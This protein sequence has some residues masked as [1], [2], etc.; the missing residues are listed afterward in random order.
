MPVIDKKMYETLKGW[1]DYDAEKR[2][3]HQQIMYVNSHD[4]T[5][6]NATIKKMMFEMWKEDVH[7][8]LFMSLYSAENFYRNMREYYSHIADLYLNKPGEDDALI[9]IIEDMPPTCGWIVL[10][11]EDLE[12]LSGKAEVMQE[13]MESVFTF[14]SNMPSIILVGNGEYQEVFA[15]C[16]FALNEMADG[17]AATEEDDEVMV[18]CY[19]QETEPTREGITYES[20]DDQRD[21][22]SFYWDLLYRQLEKRCFDYGD[23][24]K[25][26]KETMEYIIPR[27][28]AEQV[29]RKDIRLIENIGAI[30]RESN[31]RLDGCTPWEFDAAQECSEGLHGA[32]VNRYGC[33]DDLSNGKIMFYVAIKHPD[34]EINVVITDPDEVCGAIHFSGAIYAPM[35]VS[36]DTVFDKM[37]TLSEMILE[38]TYRGDKGRAWKFLDDK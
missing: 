33:N 15:G 5:L 24:K 7:G 6:T 35:K 8:E 22:L 28:S 4:R 23:F 27:V 21:E 29:Y 16:E 11:V 32:I 20:A 31:Q 17:I 34:E 38:H 25:L 18:G 14:S 26:F 10:I 30:C 2:P 13:M 37:D 1:C 36:A 9:D 12:L 3:K 19:D